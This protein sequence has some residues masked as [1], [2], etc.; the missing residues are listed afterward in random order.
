MEALHQVLAELLGHDRL[1]VGLGDL[2]LAVGELLEPGEGLVEPVALDVDA[3]LLE[4]VGE[5]VASR[6]LAH[7]DL[8]THLS[9]AG[10]VDDLVGRTVGQHPVLM[11]ARLVGEGV[12]PHHGLV[13]LHRVPRQAG[14][15]PRGAGQLLGAHRGRDAGELI[16]TDPQRHD[17]FLE[18]GVPGPLTEPVDAHLDLAR[19]GLHPGEGVRRG[20]PEVVVA[21]GRQ[22]VVTRDL[23]PD[24]LDEGPEVPWDAV[25]DGVGDVQ[26]GGAGFD[27]GP[28]HLQHEVER[29]PGGVLGAELHVVGVLSRPEQH[30]PV[31][32]PAPAPRSS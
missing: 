21:V 16:G 27:R 12:A 10:G 3:H 9:D 18:R 15:E 24:V 29:R 2:D 23:F 6:V 13:V 17:D 25:P 8:T 14:H 11:D 26:R 22:H 4:G 1:E 32:R 5:G 28:E 30:L 31:S 20:Q 19:P 7:D